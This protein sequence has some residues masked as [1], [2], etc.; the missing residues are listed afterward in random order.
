MEKLET[1][2]GWSTPLPDEDWSS[3]HLAMCQDFVDAVAQK[4]PAKASGSLG[5][6]VVKVIYGAYLAAA[7]GT[8]VTIA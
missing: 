8:R 1:K 3:G 4:R 2:A 5:L 7:A 6:D